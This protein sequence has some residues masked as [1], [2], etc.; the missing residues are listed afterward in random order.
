MWVPRQTRVSSRARC[1]RERLLPEP[2]EVLVGPGDFVQATDVV[3]RLALPTGLHA[4]DVGQELGVEDIVP[5]LAKQVGETVEAGEP[6]AVRKGRLGLSQRVCRAPVAGRLWQVVGSRLLLEGEPQKVEVTAY[7]RGRVVQT[8]GDRGVVVEG[9]AAWVEGAWGTGGEGHGVLKVLTGREEPLAK[10]AVD[11]S[12]RGTVAV[13]GLLQDEEPLRQLAQVQARGLVVGS[14]PTALVPVVEG[15]GLPLVATEGL[16][17][18][19]MVA[20]VH[21]LLREHEGEEVS[22]L[23]C[24]VGLHHRTRPEVVIPVSESGEPVREPRAEIAEG[25]RVRL[26]RDP[27][28]GALGH[29][30]TLPRHPEPTEVGPRLGAWVQLDDGESVFVPWNNLEVIG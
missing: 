1:W 29:V 23:G 30:T 21:D 5:F 3:A 24:K 7:L 10:G 6:L 16:G 20:E 15:M 18:V 28:R 19:P 17:R 27:F 4:V 13:C 14:L 8:V 9:K 22:L 26:L 11:I 12:C 25:D 2:G